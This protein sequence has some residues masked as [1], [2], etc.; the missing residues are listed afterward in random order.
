MS[1]ATLNRP[2]NSN[3][4]R[5]PPACGPLPGLT[6]CHALLRLSNR[7]LCAL[8]LIPALLLAQQPQPP[9]A[10]QQTQQPPAETASP[11][12]VITTGALNLQNASLTEVI[13]ILCRLLKINYILDPRVKG[14]VTLNTYGETRQL[15]ARQLLDLILRINGATM[16]QVGEI[17]RIVPMA[18]APRL[19]I[20]PRRAE[21]S[22]IPDDEQM[23]I[24]LIFLKYAT[25]GDVAKLL[26]PF[27]GEGA[28]IFQ[29]VPANMLLIMDS[30]RNMRR[31]MELISLF[32]SDT[33]AS[34]RVRLFEVK[35]GSPSDIAR[36]L[37]TILKTISLAEKAS[38][39]T[40]LPVDR[41][42]L[43]IAIAPNPAVFEEV[44]KWLKKLD[45]EIQ[46]TA[47]GIDNY[48]YRVKYGRAEVIA[49]AIM[50]LYSGNPFFMM[51][52]GA[53]GGGFAGA[54][55]PGV[56][57][58]AGMF[59]GGFGGGLGMGMM[60]FPFSGMPFGGGQYPAFSGYPGAGQAG[61]LFGMPQYPLAATP[62]Q[63]QPAAPS[64]SG[65]PPDQTGSY[66]GFP[67]FG[68]SERMPRVM[69]NPF[70][71]T[72]LI[73]ATPQEYQQILKLLRSIDV[74]P[75]QVLIDAKVYEVSLTG[76]F[77]SGVAAFFQKQ[78]SGQSIPTRQL[79]GSLAQGAVNLSAGWLVE[80]SRELIAFL[81]L[82]ETE[83]RARVIS[84]PSVIATD[85][86]NATITVG[87][88]VPTLSAT[89]V[90][91]IQSGGSSLFA[92][93]I[94]NRSAGV[95]L[96]ILARVNP[97]GIV[98]MVINQEVSAPI[99]PEAGGIQS[100]SFSRRNVSTQVTVQDGDTIAIG[101]IINETNSQSSAGI[102]VLHR[103][104]II[105]YAFGSK[106]LARERTELVIFITPR[107]IYDTNEIT[108]ASE[109]LK[110]RFRRVS[111]IFRE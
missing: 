88:E 59:P 85:S 41:L 84:S 107:V 111:K 48:L 67:G 54:G 72:I 22:E 100:P 40:F 83:S 65:Q 97:S 36:E 42:N 21:L 58:G 5:V 103:I 43:I 108:E 49:T 51:S 45:T 95:T 75:R 8:L 46:V 55:T 12:P 73:Q 18:D 33:L 10:Q 52:L 2:Q 20:P 29:Y 91:P 77:A 32:D 71:N 94:Q 101:G 76:A 9:A 28:R 98:T 16:V 1:L 34:Q 53:M 61:A 50:G 110:S 96:A 82:A 47:G 78:G 37:E 27:V 35:N 69:P 64:Q 62:Q 92:N 57:A 13:D 104:P 25:V 17:Y 68:S 39:V 31:T 19:P 44:E 30:R 99:A 14:S 6:R 11:Q 74:P 63:G 87:V 60:G 15:D 102:P 23:M 80:R 38:L 24:N 7:A 105:G 4:T 106:S 90:T 86:I 79:T 3:T 109:E 66:L 26:E 81:S 70:D 89:S 93:Q 56:G